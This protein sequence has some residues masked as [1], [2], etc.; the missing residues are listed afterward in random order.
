MQIGADRSHLATTARGGVVI[1]NAIICAAAPQ[2]V[3]W[4]PAIK[5]D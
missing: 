3:S 4:L 5:H 1:A 2:F